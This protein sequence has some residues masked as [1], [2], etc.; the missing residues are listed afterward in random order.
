MRHWYVDRC[1]WTFENKCKGCALN[2]TNTTNRCKA[3]MVNWDDLAEG[4]GDRYLSHHELRPFVG[5]LLKL[6]SAQISDIINYNQV[7]TVHFLCMDSVSIADDAE[8]YQASLKETKKKNSSLLN[9]YSRLQVISCYSTISLWIFKN[10]TC[11]VNSNNNLAVWY[12]RHFCTT[13][14]TNWVSI[15]LHIHIRISVEQT[16]HVYFALPNTELL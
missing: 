10:L 13:I 11:K 15:Q 1:I 8:H 2:R 5:P 16:R 4:K 9:E 14:D 6:C 7:F 12:F 3:T